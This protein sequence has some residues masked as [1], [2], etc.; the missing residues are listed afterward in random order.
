M[1]CGAIV[2]TSTAAKL[3]VNSA[4]TI[5]TQ[6]V[7]NTPNYCKGAAATALQVAATGDGTLS[8]QWYKIL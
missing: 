8:Y 4:L 5:N 7:A 6:P 3:T 2:Q 1:L